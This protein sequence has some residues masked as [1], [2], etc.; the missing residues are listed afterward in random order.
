MKFEDYGKAI[1]VLAAVTSAFALGFFLGT[2]T[3]KAKIPEYQ[4]DNYE[5]LA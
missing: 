5:E 1:L 4:E 2:E 3:E